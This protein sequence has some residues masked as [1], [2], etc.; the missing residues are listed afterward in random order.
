MKIR[1]NNSTRPPRYNA[2]DMAVILRDFKITQKFYLGSA[3]PSYETYFNALAGKYGLVN[4]F[5]RHA[6]VEL[7]EIT[8]ADVKRAYK[9]KEMH[10]VLTPQLYQLTE[11]GTGK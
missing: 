5:K 3:T 1:L 7:P 2:R 8:V 11:Q 4:L 6:K 9:R 10:S